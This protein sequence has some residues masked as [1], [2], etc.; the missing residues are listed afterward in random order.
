MFNLSSDFVT[1]MIMHNYGDDAQKERETVDTNR[2]DCRT[3]EVAH[4]KLEAKRAP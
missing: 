1:N 2:D 3:T 4:R